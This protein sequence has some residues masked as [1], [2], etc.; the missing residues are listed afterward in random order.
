MS[1]ERV[2]CVELIGCG[3]IEGVAGVDPERPPGEGG[4]EAGIEETTDLLK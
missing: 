3:L 2:I 1:N 4:A